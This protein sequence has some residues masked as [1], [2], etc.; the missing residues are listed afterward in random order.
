ME[1]ARQLNRDRRGLATVEMAILLP[2]LLLVILAI[3]E[4]GW[5]FLKYQC[6]NSATREGVRVAVREGATDAQWQT[7]VT[8]VMAG[9]GKAGVVPTYTRTLT[10]GVGA[11]S[12]TELTCRVTVPY[13][14]L[15]ITSW[16]LFPLPTNLVAVATMAKEGPITP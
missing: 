2:L 8:N 14:Q 15:N 6:V 1:N 13:A 7:A 11:A 10:P 4:Y 5:C 3:L 16:A 12:G 9:C